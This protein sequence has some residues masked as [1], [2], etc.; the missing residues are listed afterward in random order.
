MIGG[1]TYLTNTGTR[2]FMTGSIS[3][4]EA[5][6]SHQRFDTFLGKSKR[7]QVSFYKTHFIRQKFTRI[8]KIKGE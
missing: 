7:H 2:V 4:A 6:V 3:V 1:H 5:Y 8:S